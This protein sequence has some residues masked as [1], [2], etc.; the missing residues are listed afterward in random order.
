VKSREGLPG[1]MPA[2]ILKHYVREGLPHKHMVHI[3]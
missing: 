2:N 1:M 3:S